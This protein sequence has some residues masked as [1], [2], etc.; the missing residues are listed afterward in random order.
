[1]LGHTRLS[2]IDLSANGRQ[3]MQDPETGNCVS[4]NG[5]IYNY[6]ILRAGLEAEGDRFYSRTDTEVILALYR[7]YGV[8]SLSRLRGMFAF[9]I[10]DEGKKRLLLVRDRMGKKPLNYAVTGNG[11]ALCS[12]IRALARHPVRRQDF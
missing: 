5:E 9:V 12:E 3:P 1:M 8:E 2:I 4:F 10:W 11:I 6:R 7:R